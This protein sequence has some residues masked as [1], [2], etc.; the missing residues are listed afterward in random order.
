M[1][2]VPCHLASRSPRRLAL[3]RALGVEPIPCAVD[4]P[5]ERLDGE[6]P[7]RMAG[8]LAESKGRAALARLD[9]STPGWLIAAD[10]IV[11]L[12]GDVLGKPVD[13]AD[14]AAMLRRLSGRTHEVMTGVFVCRTDGTR[15]IVDVGTTR[16]RFRTLD[17]ATIDA[18]VAGGEPLDKAGGYGIQ[19]GGAMLVESIDGSW[20]NVVGLPLERLPDALRAIDLDPL[21]TIGW[22]AAA[23]H[24]SSDSA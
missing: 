7:R 4:V 21:R 22:S 23:D 19:A 6:P 12:D 10:T 15:S 2:P 1:T 18:Y 14:A 20:T 17:A 13:A 16:V 8:R 24:P 11:V 9:G 5:E 3:L